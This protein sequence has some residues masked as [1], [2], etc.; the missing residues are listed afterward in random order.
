MDHISYL[1]PYLSTVSH[2]MEDDCK[3][4]SNNNARMD[5]RYLNSR[6]Y[7]SLKEN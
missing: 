2:A 1:N 3:I 5:Y 4:Q 6:E 7:L